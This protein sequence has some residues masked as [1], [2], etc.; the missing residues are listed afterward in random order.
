MAPHSD[1]VILRNAEPSTDS[2]SQ[3]LYMQMWRYAT[4]KQPK[5]CLSTLLNCI[6]VVEITHREE[7]D[8]RDKNQDGDN[9][10]IEIEVKKLE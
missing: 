10:G 3:F 8:K 9:I 1:D 6:C 7:G 2:D 4:L 5:A